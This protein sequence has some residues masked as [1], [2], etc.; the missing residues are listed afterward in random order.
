M[1]ERNVMNVEN[2]VVEVPID[3]IVVKNGVEGFICPECNDFEPLEEAGLVN[4]LGVIC[5]SCADWSYRLC[6]Y[7]NRFES[8]DRH[9]FY[10]LPNGT[11]ICA[12]GLRESDEYGRCPRCGD[13]I[14]YEEHG[15]YDEES[16]DYYCEGCHREII[17]ERNTFIRGYH[18]HKGGRVNLLYSPLDN[19]Q[20]RSTLK[21]GLEIEVDSN[22]DYDYD[23]NCTAK[24]IHEMFNKTEQGRVL[25]F[26]RD[27]SLDSGFEIITEPMSINFIN[28]N[29]HKFANMLEY[30]SDEG[31]TGHD[32][33][34]CGLHIHLTKSVLGDKGIEN[35]CFFVENNQEEIVKFSR[36]KRS[37]L[38]D[39]A[40]FSLDE[41]ELRH[42]PNGRELLMRRI[43]HQSRYH[44]VNVSNSSTVEL[45]IMRGTLNKETFFAT[46]GFVSALG[47][48]SMYEEMT[49]DTDIKAIV[50]YAEVCG[51]PFVEEMKGYCVRRKIKGFVEES[52]AV[53]G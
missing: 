38:N 26:E 50:D 44:A 34:T 6:E 24:E 52:E 23:H 51:M 53:I 8:M 37:R 35:F 17:R 49:L 22:H 10:R 18:S 29:K 11:S 31:Y 33:G 21:F 46:I 40:G 12:D 42:N 45:R 25:Y 43:N 41:N 27:G 47:Y 3:K 4:E 32:K 1:I 48:Y 30:L 7:H 16:D 13:I 5:L 9:V 39:Y 15:Y 2:M 36:R 28:D 19:G 14:D 20:R